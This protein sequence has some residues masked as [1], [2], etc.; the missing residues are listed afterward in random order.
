[1]SAHP[2]RAR[3]PLLDARD[4][5]PS[6]VSLVAIRMPGQATTSDGRN[7]RYTGTNQS[8]ANALDR[9][10]KEAVFDALV[11]AA[12][13]FAFIPYLSTELVANARGLTSTSQLVPEAGETLTAALA[14]CRAA[15]ARCRGVDFRAGELED[16]SHAL[17]E[18]I[19]LASSDRREIF[20]WSTY[21][22]TAVAS[23]YMTMAQN[24]VRDRP[25][26][27]STAFAEQR[28]SAYNEWTDPRLVPEL[29]N[30]ADRDLDYLEV[31]RVVFVYHLLGS[32]RVRAQLAQSIKFCQVH[33]ER[34]ERGLRLVQVNPSLYEYLRGDGQKVV[35]DAEACIGLAEFRAFAQAVPIHGSDPLLILPDPVAKALRTLTNRW[36]AL[37]WVSTCFQP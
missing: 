12:F 28:S 27:T 15:L 36:M 13:Q 18:V 1:M 31:G 33:A 24:I 3:S 4:V 21:L 32:E 14:R 17:H 35:F 26:D 20:E 2:T 34:L 5:L 11:R 22:A 7:F 37:N 10:R 23:Y 25:A 8:V 16:D 6:L 29:T 19:M 30:R 9:M